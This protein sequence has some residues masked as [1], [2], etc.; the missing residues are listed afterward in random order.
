MTEPKPFFENVYLTE[1]ISARDLHGQ[2]A[3]KQDSG[4]EEENGRKENRAPIPDL[5]M[6]V[7][8]HVGACLAGKEQR[9]KDGEEHHVGGENGEDRKADLMK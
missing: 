5:F 6:S 1:N 9:H 7:G 4:I 3:Q 8:I 2:T